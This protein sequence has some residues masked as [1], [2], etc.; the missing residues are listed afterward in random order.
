V[1]DVVVAREREREFKRERVQE[2]EFKRV[3]ERER[4]S[5]TECMRERECF[6]FLREKRCTSI[7]SPDGR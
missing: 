5:S 2:R 3:Q 1:V 4:E 6:A 7:R